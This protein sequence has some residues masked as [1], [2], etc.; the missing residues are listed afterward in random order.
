ME[1]RLGE[2]AV[3]FKALGDE[4]RL[5]I[6]AMLTKG[7]TCACKIL[8]AFHFTQPTLSYH[9]KQLTDSGLVSGQKDGKWVYYSIN[10]NKIKLLDDFAALVNEIENAPKCCGTPLCCN[11]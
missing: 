7:K 4:T 1:Y 8:E 5:R 11:E 2:Y 9:M 6:L 10:K 3:I